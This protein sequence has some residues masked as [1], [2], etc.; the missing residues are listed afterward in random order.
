MLTHRTT[1]LLA[2]FRLTGGQN[3]FERFWR[4][5]FRE[6]GAQMK[7]RYAVSVL[8]STNFT[9]SGALDFSN[10][11]TR[12]FTP[13]KAKTFGLQK[14]DSAGRAIRRRTRPAGGSYWFYHEDLPGMTVSNFI[15]VLRPNPNVVTPS[16]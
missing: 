1:P 11:A 4:S 5:S 2:I 14:G 12:Y 13:E 3:R 9:N 16:F 10:I 15:Q 7:V 8:R 6:I